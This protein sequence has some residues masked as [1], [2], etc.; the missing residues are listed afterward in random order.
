MRADKR[1]SH[2]TVLGIEIQGDCGLL[3]G[4]AMVTFVCGLI[5]TF[6]HRHEIPSYTPMMP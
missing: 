5:I 2:L 4:M 6:I 1:F 3:F